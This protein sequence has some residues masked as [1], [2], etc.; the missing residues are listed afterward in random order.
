MYGS[1]PPIVV[2]LATPIVWV[3]ARGDRAGLRWL[4]R[5]CAA[6]APPRAT[7]GGGAM[8]AVRRAP[9]APPLPSPRSSDEP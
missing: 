5:R 7:P 3:S 9:P 2:D 8:R 1:V 6:L 4:A